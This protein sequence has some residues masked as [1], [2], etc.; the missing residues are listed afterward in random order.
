[1]QRWP[2]PWHTLVA[3]GASGTSLPCRRP[4][5]YARTCARRPNTDSKYAVRTVKSGLLA[6][7]VAST[8]FRSGQ[9]GDVRI[10]ALPPRRTL[11]VAI[12]PR[13]RGCRVETLLRGRRC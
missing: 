12:G 3:E 5:A 7:D 8:T 13:G 2:Y 9:F 11:C 1:M 10:Q 4:F 6:Q